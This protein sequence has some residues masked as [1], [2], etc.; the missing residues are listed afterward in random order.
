MVT[1]RDVALRAGVSAKTVSRVFNDDEHVSEPTRER[2]QEAMRDLGYVPN[3]LA[4][5]FRT[6]RVAA[7]GVAVPDIGDPF[8]AAVTRSIEEV[9]AEH[10]SAVVVT[11]LGTDPERERSGLEALLRR[12]ISGLVATPTSRDQRYLEPWLART[13]IVFIDR[14]PEGVRADSFVEG[15]LEAARQATAHLVGHGHRRIAFLGDDVRIPTTA[16]RLQGYRDALSS[17]ASPPIHADPALEVLTGWPT[18]RAE[19]ELARLLA[20][21]EPPTALFSSNARITQE[22][23][24]AQHRMGRTDVAVVSFGDLPLAAA[25][26]P[27]LTVVDQN[28]D[29]LGRRAAERVF[30]RLADPERR[31]RR[32][33]VLP[34]RLV[35]RGSGELR[36]PRRGRATPV[37]RRG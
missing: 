36:A 6:G 19:A 35:A 7:I 14:T 11:S 22:V 31:F 13:P 9:A 33:T 8:F 2:V 30:A 1:M 18:D 32:T 34:V 3:T 26:Q 37:S 17:L 15:D 27:G 25:L 23:V 4:Q 20:L 28:P 12:Q 21:P 10:A 16:N 29:E 24:T 5:T